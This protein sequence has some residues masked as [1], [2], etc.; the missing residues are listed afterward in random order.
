MC[1][2]CYDRKRVRRKDICLNCNEFKPIKAKGMCPSCYR[3]PKHICAGC[4]KLRSISGNGLCQQCYLNDYYVKPEKI[5]MG[6]GE[7]DTITGKGLCSK[8]YGRQ[9]V[10]PSVV[11]DSCG[12][13]RPHR[14]HGLC[15]KCYNARKYKL[16]G[17]G[18][19]KNIDALIKKQNSICALQITKECKGRKGDMSSL[20]KSKIH[21][22]HIW[23]VSRAGEYN[24]DINEITNLQAVC[25]ACNPSKGNKVLQEDYICQ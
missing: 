8:C 16:F 7:L 9:Y 11:C 14:G 6:C 25:Y 13:F 3:A 20:D 22:D 17:Q 4:N 15:A 21:V 24:G 23:P 2:T 12:D 5:C 1:G 10:A 18:Y 19:R